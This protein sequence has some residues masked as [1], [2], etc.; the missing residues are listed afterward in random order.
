MYHAM[1][2][3]YVYT[4]LTGQQNHQQ[5]S[6]NANRQSHHIF[7][8]N[9]HLGPSIDLLQL[10]GIEMPPIRTNRGYEHGHG[11]RGGGWR[12]RGNHHSNNVQV[13]PPPSHP[14]YRQPHNNQ[15]GK[16]NLWNNKNMARPPRCTVQQ[17]TNMSD[18]TYNSDS[19]FSS[20]SPTPIKLQQG[21]QSN[22]EE[23][24]KDSSTNSSSGDSGKGVKRVY[25]EVYSNTNLPHYS[26]STSSNGY[27]TPPPVPPHPPPPITSAQQFY[28]HVPPPPAPIFYG[29]PIY[30][31]QQQQAPQ[32]PRRS[33]G[34][35]QS[36]YTGGGNN[37]HNK[38]RYQSGRF[39]PPMLYKNRMQEMKETPKELLTGGEWDNSAYPRYGLYLVG[40]TISGFGS[41]NSDVD[42]CLL[43]RHTEMD[44]RSEAVG[45]LEELLMCLRRCVDLLYGTTVAQ[46][47]QDSKIDWLELNETGHKLLFR[48]KKMRLTLY[49]IKTDQKLPILSFCTFVQ[50]VPGSDVVVAQ[51]RNNLCVWYNIDSPDQVTLFPIKG[52]AVDVVRADGKT[53]VVVEEGQHQ[54]GYELDEGL[55]EFGTAI[56]DNDLGQAILF[57]EK[58]GDKPEA[59]GMWSILANIAIATNKLRVAERCYAALGDVARTN[60][61]RETISIKDQ[62]AK[63]NGTDGN[64]CPEVWAQM[65]LLNKQFKEAESIYLEQNQ[66]ER[67]LDMY[68]RLHKW[69]EAL[70]LAEMK[71]HPRL[72]ELKSAHMKWL[73]ESKQEEKAGEIKEKEGDHETALVHYL[74]AGLPSLA[75]SLLYERGQVLLDPK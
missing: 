26:N 71:G 31:Q 14:A 57:L 53:E 38:R 9:P 10:M 49:D 54:L 35:D 6:S 66:L 64:D 25:H 69:D 58:L 21:D 67:A 46:V 51:S 2:P 29:Y 59:E 1:F 65:A 16:K 56:H 34:H 36:V 13:M 61:L 12:E 19:G 42:M 39:S 22:L 52:D 72:E 62:Y 8:S 37:T 27:Q 30:G 24:C 43:V 48:D 47:S 40:S 45:H 60:F 55:L 4:H 75:A 73:L 50:W 28:H 63:D 33:D 7:G 11:G 68:R 70:A 44:Q 15:N 74:R 41:D 17:D 3:P 5:Y 18:T 23:N 20:R 32:Q